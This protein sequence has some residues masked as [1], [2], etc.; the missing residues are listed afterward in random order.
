MM[1]TIKDFIVRSQSLMGKDAPFIPG[2]DCHG[3]P[4]EWKIEEQY[5]KKKLDKDQVPAAE[6]RAECRAYAEHWVNVQR[7]QFKRL[8]SWATGKTPTEPWTSS[9]KRRSRPSS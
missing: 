2:W 4:I 5:R 3:L 6:F 1:K 8:G 7:E 9:P